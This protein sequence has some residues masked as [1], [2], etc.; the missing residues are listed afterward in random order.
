MATLPLELIDKIFLLNPNKIISTYL[1][2]LQNNKNTS[3]IYNV[4][5]DVD[6]KK[7]GN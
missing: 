4:D 6:S 3:D 1:A 7:K 5:S 2:F